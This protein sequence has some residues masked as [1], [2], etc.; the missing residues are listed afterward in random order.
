MPIIG[1][2]AHAQESDK[3][4]G[5]AAGMDDYMSKPISPELLEQKIKEWLGEPS[6]SMSS[7]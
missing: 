6:A 7:R 3:E 5:I 1:V 2:T 4:L